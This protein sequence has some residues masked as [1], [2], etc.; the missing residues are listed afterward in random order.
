MSE[1]SSC[2]LCASAVDTGALRCPACGFYLG[3]GSGRASPFSYASWW[4][5]LGGLGA[6]YLV[7][8]LI[9]ALAR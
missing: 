2:P 8:L 5:M 4:A 1:A 3:A 7:A 6:V 9:V